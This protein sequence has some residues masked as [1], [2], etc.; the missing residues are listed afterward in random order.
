MKNPHK[1]RLFSEFLVIFALGPLVVWLIGQW[2]PGVLV[3]LIPLL[4]LAAL[5]CAVVLLLDR[6]FDRGRF[7]RLRVPRRA[8]PVVLGR[9]ALLAALL[10]V[11]VALLRPESLL[12]LP[13]Q[14]PGRWVVLMLLYPWLSVYPQGIIWRAFLLHRYAPLFGM[15]WAAI[16]VA[17]AAFAWAHAP[18][19]NIPALGLTFIGGLM[20]T[21]TYLKYRS[22]W[23]AFFEHT[24]YG[25]FVFTIG[26]GDFLRDG[27]MGSLGVLLGG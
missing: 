14:Q 25:C 11:L 23:L 16:V 10:V 5:G 17:A 7:C 26:L 3:T 15:G 13:R 6:R 22:L 4:W 9:F 27:T 1:R 24:L 21:H 8:W 19:D 12:N 20:F 18:F 2:Q